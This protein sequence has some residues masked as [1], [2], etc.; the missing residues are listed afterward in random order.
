MCRFWKLLSKLVPDCEE[1]GWLRNGFHDVYAEGSALC[2]R[3]GTDAC[4]TGEVADRWGAS[5][6]ISH[7]LSDF[8]F[9]GCLV[10]SIVMP[11]T[12]E[13]PIEIGV[14]VRGAGVGFLL[15]GLLP[16]PNLTSVSTARST[17]PFVLFKTSVF[18]LLSSNPMSR[19]V[20]SFVS[21]LLPTLV[22]FIP[23][24]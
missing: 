8:L 20:A 3:G 9:S 13:A 12:P 6:N 17:L 1:A 22:I 11:L 21:K 5:S 2:A 19:R 16:S 24:I 7:G 18:R 4:G 23:N 14:N 10:F 15:A